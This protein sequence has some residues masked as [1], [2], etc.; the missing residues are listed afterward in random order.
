MI[1]A[2]EEVETGTAELIGVAAAIVILLITFG[3]VIAMGLPIITAL[4]GVVIGTLVAILGAAVFDL[5]TITT[6]FVSMM[7]LGVGIDYFLF[8][9]T[10]VS[11]RDASRS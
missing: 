5:N 7:G 9:V 10:A 4:V 3:S 2:S 6:A 8:I 11:A 1:S